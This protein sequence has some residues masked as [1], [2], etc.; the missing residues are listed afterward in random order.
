[1]HL[2]AVDQKELPEQWNNTK[3]LAISVKQ[4][5]APLQANEVANI[6]RKLADF[7]SRQQEFREDFRKIAAFSYS[8]ANPYDELDKVRSIAIAINYCRS[9]SV[10]LSVPCLSRSVT[11]ERKA[12]S[13]HK[14]DGKVAHVTCNMTFK[15]PV[16][17]P[18]LLFILNLITAVSYTHLTLP[19]KRIV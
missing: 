2:L 9:Q 11:R 18:L 14:M 10:R 19:T 3:K 4:Q 13:K 16:P 1:M 6:R 8:C 5:V 7:D 17:S 12:Y 15:L